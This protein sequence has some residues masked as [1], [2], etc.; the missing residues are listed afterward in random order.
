MGLIATKHLNTVLGTEDEM[1]AV[2][3][4]DGY[5]GAYQGR[6]KSGK[7]HAIRLKFPVPATEETRVT[8]SGSDAVDGH[9]RTDQPP[10]SPHYAGS[11]PHC[12]T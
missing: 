10:W 7:L 1:P 8:V 3:H 2:I 12:G 11:Y 4:V 5:V 6:K 9:G